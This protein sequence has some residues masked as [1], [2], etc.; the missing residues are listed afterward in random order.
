MVGRETKKEHRI[1]SCLEDTGVQEKETK[2]IRVEIKNRRRYFGQECL[3][4]FFKNQI[5]VFL[6]GLPS[7]NSWKIVC[8]V[9]AIIVNYDTVFTRLDI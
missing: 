9:T 6:F 1:R 4:C 2:D 7:Q 3:Q 8:I 5:F